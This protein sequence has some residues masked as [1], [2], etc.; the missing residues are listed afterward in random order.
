ME[1]PV[2]SNFLNGPWNMSC[3]FQGDCLTT[4]RG[5]RFWNFKYSI[6]GKTRFLNSTTLTKNSIFWSGKKHLVAWTLLYQIT[7][8]STFI[9]SRGPP[10]GGRGIRDRFF[11]FFIV[12][13]REEFQLPGKSGGGNCIKAYSRGQIATLIHLKIFL[14]IFRKNLNELLN[15]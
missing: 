15:L 4:V 5:D 12:S 7:T 3:K 10:K 14:K 13:D 2:V 6:F 1:K 8:Y 9:I 11:S